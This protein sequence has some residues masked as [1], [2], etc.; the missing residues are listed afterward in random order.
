MSA[1]RSSLCGG[2]G[3]NPQRP[4]RACFGAK[5]RLSP[6]AP[7]AYRARFGEAPAF[8]AAIH[9]GPVVFGELG[10]A[11]KEIALIGD[12]MNT[13]ARILEAARDSG[14]SVLISAGYYE[15]MK[16]PLHGVVAKALGP[17]CLCVANWS[18]CR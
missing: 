3:P 4:I 10:A 6:S 1:T 9:A 12:A 5:R 15:R 2:R 18:R 13:A 11:K 17:D 16:A 7:P 8:R 14:A